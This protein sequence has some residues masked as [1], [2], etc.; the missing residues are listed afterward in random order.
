METEIKVEE[1]KVVIMNRRPPGDRWSIESDTSTIYNSLTS[2]LDGYFQKTGTTDFY[3]E[4]G[5][6]TVSVIVTEET[7]I[8][9]PIQAYSL[10]GEY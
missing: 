3:I 4:A 6:G 9:K 7:E 1:R 2:A 10:Y 5:K 8:Q